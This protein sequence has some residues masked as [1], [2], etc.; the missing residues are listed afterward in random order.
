ML[1]YVDAGS[2]YGLSASYVLPHEYISDIHTDPSRAA[3]PSGALS[4]FSS[5]IHFLFLGGGLAVKPIGSKLN[6]PQSAYYQ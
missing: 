6:G 5:F 3:L 2:E 4:D 1:F